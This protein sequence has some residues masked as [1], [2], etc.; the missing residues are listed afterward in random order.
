MVILHI[1]VPPEVAKPSGCGY[2]RNGSREFE[3]FAPPSDQ[4]AAGLTRAVIG[5]VEKAVLAVPAVEA[6]CA[7]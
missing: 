4:S 5:L 6:K 1:K 3:F 2:P 7:V